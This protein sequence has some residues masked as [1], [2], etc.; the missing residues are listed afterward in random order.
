MSILPRSYEILLLVVQF[1]YVLVITTTDM[2]LGRC[3]S[4][5]KTT[6]YHG[7]CGMRTTDT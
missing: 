1:K 3:I 2:L 4:S 5:G 6:A 7:V